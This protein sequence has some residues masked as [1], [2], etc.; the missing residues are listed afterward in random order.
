MSWKKLSKMAKAII[1]VWG[2]VGLAYIL[3][4]IIK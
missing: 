2:L 4:L 3:N 1:I